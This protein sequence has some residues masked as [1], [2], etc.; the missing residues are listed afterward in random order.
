MNNSE[1]GEV[2]QDIAGLLEMKGEKR[3]TVVAY[4]RAARALAHH[5][6]DL[7]QAV[8]DGADLT[9]IPGVGKAIAAKTAEL[10]TTGRMAFFER[11]RAEFPDGI[12]DVMR[13]PGIGPKTAK[14]ISDELG[15][16]TVADLEKA[17]ESGQLAELPRMGREEGRQ[18]PPRDT[19]GPYEGRPRPHGTGDAGGRAADRGAYGKLPEH[20]RARGRGQPAALSRRPSATSTWS[21]RPATRNRCSAPSSNS[22]TSPRCSCTATRRPPSC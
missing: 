15:V 9:E 13:V 18:R 5:P 16:S 12:L 14:L 19:R 22:L 2:F 7:G 6:V 1:I 17:I 11:L 20:H 8:R 3:F 4:Q 21:A 10:V